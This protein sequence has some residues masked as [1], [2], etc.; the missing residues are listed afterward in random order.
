MLSDRLGGALARWQREW[1]TTDVRRPE[2]PTEA[3]V[4][5]TFIATCRWRTGVAGNLSC[6]VGC[7]ASA[8]DTVVSLLVGDCARSTNG[9]SAPT[10]ASELDRAALDALIVSLL[11]EFAPAAKRATIEWDSEPP[12]EARFDR[13]HGNFAARLRLG[14]VDVVVL[15]SAVVVEEFLK[16]QPRLRPSGGQAVSV[17]AALAAQRVAVEVHAGAAQLTLAELAS[18]GVG[19]VITLDR[20]L[21]RPLEVRAAGGGV[22]CSAHLGVRDGKKAIQLAAIHFNE[23]V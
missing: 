5:A 16:V 10:A 23:E 21:D 15:L 7:V 12:T 17:R 4:D 20:P 8:P 6:S 3:A 13:R 9:E 22:Y 18:L 1:C 19:D 2:P 14:N 11:D